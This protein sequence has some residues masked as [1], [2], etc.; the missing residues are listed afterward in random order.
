MHPLAAHSL[1]VAAVAM[2]LPHPTAMALP[3]RT[4]GFLV[5]LHHIGKF[6]RPFQ[7]LALEHWPASARS[8]HPRG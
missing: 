4:L 7:S 2:L 1:D 3:R 5:A 8:P 6:S